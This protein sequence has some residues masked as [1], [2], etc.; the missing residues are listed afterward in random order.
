MKTM[1]RK[2][3]SNKKEN[4][5]RPVKSCNNTA[6]CS[7]CPVCSLFVFQPGFTTAAKYILIVK[8]YTLINTGNL[9]SYKVKVWK[10]PNDYLPY[11]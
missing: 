4:T 10:P 6:G 9:S 8:N 7:S 5:P 2:Q 11:T 3:C 1:E